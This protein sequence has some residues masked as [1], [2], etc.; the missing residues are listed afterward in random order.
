MKSGM[1]LYNHGGCENRGCEAIVRTTSALFADAAD[2]QLA[3]DQAAYDRGVALAHVSTV[4]SS[5]ISPYSLDRLI[6]SVAFRLGAPRED[7]VAR[8]YAPV[9]RHGKGRICLSIG[10]DTYCYGRPEHLIVINRRLKRQGSPMALW[11]CSIEPDLLQGELLE[12]LKNYDLIVARESITYGALVEAGLP[13]MLCCDPAFRLEKKELPLPEGWR[14][15][16]TV[17]VNVSPLVLAKA[18]DRE[19]ALDAFTELIRHILAESTDAVALIPHVTW[20]HDSDLSALSELKARF[21]QEPRVL[22]I[23][24][25]LNACELKGYIARLKALITARTHASIAAYSSCVPTLVIGYSVK[26]RGIARDLFGDEAG[27]LIPVQELHSS[28]QL[29]AAY[30]ELLARA[31]REREELAGLLPD[32]TKKLDEA[33]RAVMALGRK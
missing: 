15:G 13:A 14:E 1:L 3:S 2:V 30:D 23:P 22:M 29:I 19:K 27:H 4:F 12:D 6:N 20:G 28:E 10:G 17:G 16:A 26:A 21:A 33:A 24:G 11:G 7:E 25:T 5:Q 31:P 8:K 32:Y 18:K 9:I